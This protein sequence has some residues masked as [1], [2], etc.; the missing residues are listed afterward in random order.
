MININKIIINGKIISISKSIG[1]EKNKFYFVKIVKSRIYKGK[2]YSTFFDVKVYNEKFND[3]K[4][5]FVINKEILLEG[6]LDSYIKDNNLI[7]F[8]ILDKVSD[9]IYDR[10]EDII[11]YDVDGTMLWHGKRCEKIPML[12]EEEEKLKKEL[13]EFE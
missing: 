2:K 10:F 4:D 12:K 1:E 5:K 9:N 8:I 6:K 11:S 13:S 7:T 3:N